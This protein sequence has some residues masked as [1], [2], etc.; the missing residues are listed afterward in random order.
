MRGTNTGPRRFGVAAATIAICALAS[1]A[2]ASPGAARQLSAGL[3]GDPYVQVGGD[4]VGSASPGSG[5]FGISGAISGD[6]ST[7]IVGAPT[8]G[9]SGAAYVYTPSAS[10]WTQQAE[11]TDPS[12]PSM[13]YLGDSVAISG[14]GDTALVGAPNAQEVLVYD[15]SGTTWSLASTISA[16]AT[17][18]GFGI[19]LSLSSDGTTALIGDSGSTGPLNVTTAYVYGLV[20]STWH[21]QA[22]LSPTGEASNGIDFNPASVALSADAS[23]A[24]LGNAADGAGNGSAWVFVQSGGSWSQQGGPLTASGEIGTGGFGGSTALSGNG[25]TAAIGAIYDNCNDGAGYV[26]ARSG[27]TWALQSSKLTNIGLLGTCGVGGPTFGEGAALSA[28]GTI[29]FFGGGDSALFTL[30]GSTWG[31][32]QTDFA[33]GGATSLSSDGQTGLTTC[34][35]CN[36]GSGTAYVYHFVAGAALPA[37]MPSALMISPS[38]MG[39]LR[40]ATA[41]AIVHVHYKVNVKATAKLQVLERET[42]VLVAGDCVAPASG[43]T[44]STCSRLVQTTYF[45][46]NAH[47][48]EN[49]YTLPSAAVPASGGYELRLIVMRAR[50]RRNGL[51]MKPFTVK[52]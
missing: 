5:L 10:S 22:V 32:T 41:G 6:A 34:G 15:R 24:L 23:T 36:A 7:V 45:T 25:D 3:A 29:A 18:G 19:S 2:S 12:L 1:V 35:G 17:I 52:G 38:P 47:A 31:Q 43:V 4:L 9:S 26:F 42:G 50:S 33:G 8:E 13:A 46:L 20:G 21:Q 30:T 48:G 16:P 37:P 49:S 40:I 11:L 27:T 39:T 51:A 44:G 14:D 28:D